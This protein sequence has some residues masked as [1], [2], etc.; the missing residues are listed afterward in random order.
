MELV[1]R[2]SEHRQ[3]EIRRRH[4]HH[5]KLLKSTLIEGCTT[6]GIEINVKQN[7]MKTRRPLSTGKFSATLL[8]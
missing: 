2:K 6:Y 7:K 3:P 4:R 5:L 8:L 1:N